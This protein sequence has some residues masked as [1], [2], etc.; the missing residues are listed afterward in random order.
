MVESSLTMNGSDSLENHKNF[1]HQSEITI[2]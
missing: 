1:Q 2:L